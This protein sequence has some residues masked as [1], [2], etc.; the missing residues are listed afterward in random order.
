MPTEVPHRALPANSPAS[1]LWRIAAVPVVAVAA[2]LVL[3]ILARHQ[4]V[5]PA[6]LTARCDA[7]P[8]EGIACVLRTLTV[9]AFAAQRLGMLALAAA[10]LAT[11]TRWRAPA[12]AAAAAG[13]AGLVLYST[14]LS[15]PAVLLAAL[16]LV[17]P[18]GGRG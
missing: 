15:A 16:V 4:L 1:R 12:I 3:A 11:F 13:S 7:A 5:E 17:R 6:D 2:A 18:A 9:Q 8:W 14:L 10:I